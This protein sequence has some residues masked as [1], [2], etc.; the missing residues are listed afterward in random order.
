M[1]PRWRCHEVPQADLFEAEH[2]ERREDC[3]D[4]PEIGIGA[5]TL[6]SQVPRQQD[7]DEKAETRPNQMVGAQKADAPEP[8]HVGH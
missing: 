3:D 5:E 7:R 1:L 8:S 4:A 6:R 2:G